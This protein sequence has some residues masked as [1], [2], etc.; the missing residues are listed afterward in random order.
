MTDILI[1]NLSQVM[2][3]TGSLKT[4]SLLNRRI[5]PTVK[6]IRLP[7]L[8]VM[9]KLCP[10]TSHSCLLLKILL[11]AL[12]RLKKQTWTTNKFVLCW[13]HHSTYRSEKQ[14]RNDRKFITLKREGLMSSSSQELNFIGT[15]RSVALFS[16]R[17]RLSQD[18]FS[19][20]ATLLM[21]EGVMNRF[22]EIPSSRMFRNLFLMQIEITCLLKQ[23]PN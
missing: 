23:D 16:H 12:L 1:H 15:R 6:T 7:K 21:F 14:V 2:S 10:T 3:P 8:R 5:L 13:L 11:K 18:A 9:S 20:R 17:R 19:E 4:R 22:S